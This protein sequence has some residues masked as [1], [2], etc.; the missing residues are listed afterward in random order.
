MGLTLLPQQNDKGHMQ[1]DFGDAHEW[2]TWKYCVQECHLEIP[3]TSIPNSAQELEAVA[4]T[5]LSPK[6]VIQSHPW[7]ELPCVFGCLLGLHLLF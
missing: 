1:K 7:P 4:H 5:R 3:M 2:L 6:Y